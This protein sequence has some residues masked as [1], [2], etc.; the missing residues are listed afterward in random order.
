MDIISFGRPIKGSF[1]RGMAY[2]LFSPRVSSLTAR[3][4]LSDIRNE[5][6][7][8]QIFSNAYLRR[9]NTSIEPDS[10]GSVTFKPIEEARIWKL[11]NQAESPLRKK[12]WFPTLRLMWNKGGVQAFREIDVDLSGR[13]YSINRALDSFFINVCTS[14][15]LLSIA[16]QVVDHDRLYDFRGLAALMG[17]LLLGHAFSYLVDGLSVSTS[18][19]LFNLDAFMDR[20]A[21]KDK[22]F[23]PP[24]GRRPS[25]RVPLLP[26]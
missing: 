14:G 5:T 7:N 6:G 2:R 11:Q 18:F 20:D 16:V 15:S 25:A 10:H 17:G 13:G 21:L 9:E 8:P 23:G 26:K 24:L 19:Y 3:V 4:L 12:F 22:I 1:F